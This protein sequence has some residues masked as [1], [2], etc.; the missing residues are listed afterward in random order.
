MWRITCEKTFEALQ[1][2]FRQVLEIEIRCWDELTKV[3]EQG[4]M[5][6]IGSLIIGK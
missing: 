5:V 6:R 2:Q 4:R 3:K 1:F